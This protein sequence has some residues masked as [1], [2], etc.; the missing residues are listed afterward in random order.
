[1]VHIIYVEPSGNGRAVD[2]TEDWSLMQSATT[3][4][5]DGILGECGGSCA[6]GTCHCNIE[7]TR[8]AELPPPA[9]SEI[10]MLDCAAA[11]IRPNSRLCCQI[12][13]T[14]AAR[15]ARGHACGDARLGGSKLLVEAVQHLIAGQHLGEACVRFAPFADGCEK[16]AILQLDP[17]DRHIDP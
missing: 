4:G 13:A 3:N 8:F 1:M 10:D 9:T 16:F 11:E 15:R 17:V 5:V 2:V 14:A 6:C 12:K 7:G